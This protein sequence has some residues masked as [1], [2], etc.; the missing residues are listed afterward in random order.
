MRSGFLPQRLTKRALAALLLHAFL[1]AAL[2]LLAWGLRT[3]FVMVQDDW[4]TFWMTLPAIMLIQTG[5]FYYAG[6]CHRSWYSVSF[7]DL[8]ML[9]HSA[10]LSLL[11][12][13]ALDR[14]FVRR[15]HPSA[16]VLLIDWALTILV[17]GGLRAI[18][19]LS[20]EEL[21]PRLWR[22]GYRKALIVGANQSGETLARH[23]LSDRRLKYQPLGYLDHDA[24]RIG[25]TFGGIPIWGLPAHAIDIA[26]RLGVEDVLVISG[27]L[28]G[29]EL[30]QLMEGSAAAGVSIKVIPAYDD[31]LASSYSPQIRDVDINDLLRREPVTLNSD[32]ISNL[33]AGR[34]IMVTGAGGSIGSEICRQ[35]LKF[36][37]KTLLLVERAENSLFLVEQEFRALRTETQVIPCIADITD[38]ARMAQIFKFQRP[39]VVFHAAAHKH[40]PMM[41][42]NPGE[43]IKN[44]VLGTRQLAEL[45][46]E[47]GVQEFVMI[48]TDKAVNPTSIMGVS[49]QL[50]ERFVHAF[51][52]RA[53]TKFVVVR[54]GNVLASNGSVVPIFQEQIRRGG[55]ITVTHPEIERFFMTIPEA[56]QLVLQSAAMGKGGEIF[57]LDMGEPV[58]IVDL[59]RD[60]VRLSGLK[61]DDIEIVFTGLRPGEKLYEE[62]YFE[63]EKMLPTPHRKLFVAYHRPYALE[64]VNASIAEV[65]ALVHASQDDLRLKIKELV[66]EYAESNS[67]P[68]PSRPEAAAQTETEAE[69]SA[70]PTR[71]TGGSS[72]E[73]RIP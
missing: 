33:V 7:S 23:L 5:V 57:V 29:A 50:A 30:R 62:L 55:P 38:R 45:S 39:A 4:V 25:S 73:A 32:A 72:N 56:S 36:R 21:S 27:V 26:T 6:H 53:S 49:K 19:R 71:R 15:V 52:E 68:P 42:Y 2:Y 70:L 65:S 18:G 10:T 16:G 44:N 24:A 69:P 1:F 9:F 31:L 54:F 41:E 8:V 3:N 28:T 13:A 46:D 40:V 61:E 58:R 64:E 17:L 37:P 47:F 12:V 14:L 34:T 51:S 48:S 60:L 11:I 59:A 66:A 35:I 20:R 63:D 22:N 43:A 67:S